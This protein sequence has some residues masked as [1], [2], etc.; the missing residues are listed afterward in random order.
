MNLRAA[1]MEDFVSKLAS[2]DP[3]PGGG[4]VAGL[5][6]ALGAALASMVANFT[7][8]PKY[9][10]VAGDVDKVLSTTADLIERSLAAA[11]EDAVAFEAVTDAYRL[12]KE[13]DEDKA[14][15]TAAIQ[16]ALR[17]A[18][19]VPVEAADLAAA[20]LPL[21]QELLEYGNRNVLSDVGVAAACIRAAIDSAIINIAINAGAIKD[22]EFVAYLNER[23]AAVRA[24]ADEAGQLVRAVEEKVSA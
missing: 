12:P 9:E 10:S 1:S 22:E 8:G 7:T 23:I 4:A 18:A 14:A 6:S 13:S 11:D 21:C 3:A 24:A 15:R 16:A 19:E 20:A 2:R 5:L 17:K